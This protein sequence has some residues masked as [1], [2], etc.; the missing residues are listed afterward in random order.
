MATIFQKPTAKLRPR[1]IWVEP[2]PSRE[3]PP[4]LCGICGQEAVAVDTYGL[5]WCTGHASLELLCP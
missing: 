1:R 4:N 3:T 5:G 2:L